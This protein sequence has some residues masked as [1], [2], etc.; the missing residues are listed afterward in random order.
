MYDTR[1]QAVSLGTCKFRHQYCQEKWKLEPTCFFLFFK[2][3][4]YYHS[5]FYYILVVSMCL[6][7]CMSA[8]MPWSA[9]GESSL[10]VLS[11]QVMGPG[12]QTQVVRSGSSGL[13]TLSHL[14]SPLFLLFNFVYMCTCSMC[15]HMPI[16]AHTHRSWKRA[17]HTLQ[18]GL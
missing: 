18:L 14:S 15:A 1:L 10:W 4:F 2:I 9:S 7:I 16:C 8:H 13:C 17:L 3:Y 12:D 5:S 6:C 11:F